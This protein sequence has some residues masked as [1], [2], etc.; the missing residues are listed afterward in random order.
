MFPARAA[1][2]QRLA[3]RIL[4]RPRG[5]GVVRSRARHRATGKV[6]VIRRAAP[7]RTVIRNGRDVSS[8]DYERRLGRVRGRR[9]G[10]YG[11]SQRRAMLAQ[12]SPLNPE[13]CVTLVRQWRCPS[14]ARISRRSL[15][16]TRCSRTSRRGSSRLLT[17]PSRPPS[18]LRS[19]RAP[20]CSRRTAVRF[21]PRQ[22]S[23]RRCRGQRTRSARRANRS[24]SALSTNCR[25]Q[26]NAI[27]R[28]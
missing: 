12:T 23:Q 22:A 26:R 24:S 10:D 25:W 27:A 8:R 20:G 18:T 9:L 14:T 19:R 5:D 15:P 28:R 21:S 6:L 11:G 4:V 16:S 2:P 3:R 13:G 1:V 7:S 17:R